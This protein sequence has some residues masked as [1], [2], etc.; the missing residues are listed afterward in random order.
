MVAERRISADELATHLAEV[1]L[2]VEER[3]EHVAVTRDGVVVA[4]IHPANR[5]TMGT[6]QD[7]ID[8][9][10]NL[11]FPGEGFADDLEWAQSQQEPIG[12]SPWDS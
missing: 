10:G 9:V 2:N 3:G 4:V 8:K 1:L 11:Q 6:L 12:K 5:P 7:L